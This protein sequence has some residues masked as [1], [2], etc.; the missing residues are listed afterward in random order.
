VLHQDL[1]DLPRWLRQFD[2]MASRMFRDSEQFGDVTITSIESDGSAPDQEGSVR[3][4]R[5]RRMAKRT[6]GKRG[7]G[8]VATSELGDKGTS[9]NA[10]QV[11][12]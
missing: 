11:R 5:A 12:Q 3:R 8:A 4:L 10:G 6:R 9:Q 1:D 2:L 7:S